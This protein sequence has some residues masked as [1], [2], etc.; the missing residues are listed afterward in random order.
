MRWLIAIFSLCFG[1]VSPLS[2][3]A[4]KMPTEMLTGADLRA[5][6]IGYLAEQGYQG[7]PAIN[8][9]RL[10]GGATQFSPKGVLQLL[11]YEILFLSDVQSTGCFI[12]LT[13]DIL[14]WHS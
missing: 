7:N 2:A 14:L 3:G 10:V 1:L 13:S 4:V 9:S 12:N 11:K 6:L 8:Q 5:G